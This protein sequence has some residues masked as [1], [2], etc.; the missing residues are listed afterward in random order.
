MRLVEILLI[1]LVTVV[2][3]DLVGK[4]PQLTMLT[5]KYAFFIP[6]ISLKYPHDQI[7]DFHLFDIFVCY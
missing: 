5:G 1:T 2:G 7:F 6:L 4:A 3:V